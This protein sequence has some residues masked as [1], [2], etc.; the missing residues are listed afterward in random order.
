MRRITGHGEAQIGRGHKWSRLRTSQLNPAKIRRWS[1][2]QHKRKEER[3]K[4]EK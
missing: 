3:K 4:D 2:L 1:E